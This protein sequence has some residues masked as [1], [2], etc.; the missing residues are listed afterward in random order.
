MSSPSYEH[1]SKLLPVSLILTISSLESNC[2]DHTVFLNLRANPPAA[3]EINYELSGHAMMLSNP[4][5]SHLAAGPEKCIHEP[6]NLP[7]DALVKLMETA[8]RLPLDG[9]EI[10]PVLA[11]RIIREDERYGLITPEDFK[12][13]TGILKDS[14]RCYG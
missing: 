13:I 11:L 14:S 1:C 4:L 6:P 5:P 2:K 10:P 8:Q 3:E 12:R 9:G 7:A